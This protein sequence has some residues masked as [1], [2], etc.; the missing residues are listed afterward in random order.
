MEWCMIIQ[1]LYRSTRAA[2][3]LHNILEE[4]WGPKALRRQPEGDCDAGND[5]PA[6]PKGADFQLCSNSRM[7]VLGFYEKAN[8]G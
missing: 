1:I 3:A 8:Q 2:E 7:L 4:P 5:L 6:G